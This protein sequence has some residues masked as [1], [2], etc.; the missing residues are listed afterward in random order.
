MLRCR[1]ISIHLRDGN[2]VNP[3]SIALIKRST[4]PRERDGVEGVEGVHEERSIGVSPTEK[5]MASDS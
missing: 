1:S 5:V 3:R 4:P 2:R